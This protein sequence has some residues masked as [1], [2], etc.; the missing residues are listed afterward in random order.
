MLAGPVRGHIASV[1]CALQTLSQHAS[2]E[3]TATTVL[4][5][6]LQDRMILSDAGVVSLDYKQAFDRMG[7]T[8]T[9]QFLH[10]IGVPESFTSLVQQVWNTR[11]L[12]QYGSSYH[13]EMLVSNCT[14]QGCPFA[15][16]VLSCWML[17]GHCHVATRTHQK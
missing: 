13:D 2:M 4:F 10:R 1:P 15:P 7:A 12:V 16:L 11:R 5:S 3:S 17:S 6:L 9:S 14:P 8:I